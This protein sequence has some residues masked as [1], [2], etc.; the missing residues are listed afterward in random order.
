[1]EDNVLRDNSIG[2]LLQGDGSV[3][4]RNRIHASR[5]VGIDVDGD[6]DVLDNLVA[7]VAGSWEPRGIIA[8]HPKGN[9]VERNT[10]RGILTTGN[11][12]VGIFVG[13]TGD[14]DAHRV[15]LLDNTVVAAEANFA[16]IDCYSPNAIGRYRGNTFIGGGIGGGCQGDD[17]GDNDITYWP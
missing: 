17:A 9:T 10:V 2:I 7:G 4:R 15:S 5:G 13:S 12:G 11:Y 3:V 6:V 8:A 14:N 1:V 16:S